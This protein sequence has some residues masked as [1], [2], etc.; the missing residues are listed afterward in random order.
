MACSGIMRKAGGVTIV[1]LTGRVTLGEGSG[2]LRD[3]VNRLV[4][5]GETM[6]I[7][8]LAGVNYF[9]SAGLG[10]LVGSFA[11]VT[12]RGGALKLLNVQKR[13]H[14]VLQITRLNT[15]FEAF[16]DEAEAVASFAR[17]ARA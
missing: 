14:E 2:V 12:N 9:D 17:A 8:N 3:T 11:T 15:V 1:D 5:S 6:I 4:E 7:L 13:V 16:T 10:E